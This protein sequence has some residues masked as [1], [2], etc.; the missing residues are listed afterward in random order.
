M[1]ISLSINIK[2]CKSICVVFRL[3]NA[4]HSDFV[5]LELQLQQKI[6]LEVQKNTLLIITPMKNLMKECVIKRNENRSTLRKRVKR[7]YFVQ[8]QM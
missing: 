4:D 2:L 5:I 8:P 3:T 6:F 1:V 7:K